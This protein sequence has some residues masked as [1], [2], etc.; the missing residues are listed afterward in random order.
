MNKEA[1]GL[2][3]AQDGTQLADSILVF[4]FDEIDRAYWFQKD[5]NVDQLVKDR[6]GEHVEHA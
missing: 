2:L 4:W 5:V 3:T 6:F 1:S